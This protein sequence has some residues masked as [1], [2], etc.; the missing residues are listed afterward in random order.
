MAETAADNWKYEERKLAADAAEVSEEMTLTLNPEGRLGEWPGYEKNGESQWDEGGGAWGF[1]KHY[2]WNI[3][4]FSVG[5]PYLVIMLACLIWNLVMNIAW[6]K[7]WAGGNFWLL[8]QTF[9][10]IN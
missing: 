5:L 10:L 3:N 7:G 1:V 2:R 4:F 8:G 9:Y 6:F